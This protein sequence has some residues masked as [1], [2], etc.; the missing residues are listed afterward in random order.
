MEKIGKHLPNL[1]CL[2]TLTNT[3]SQVRKN[4]IEQQLQSILTHIA[5]WNSKQEL[6]T[7]KASPRYTSAV[8]EAIELKQWRFPYDWVEHAT[9]PRLKP[10]KA[11]RWIH[12]IIYLFSADT[13][14]L[15]HWIRHA[16]LTSKQALVRSLEWHSTLRSRRRNPPRTQKTRNT[17]SWLNGIPIS[18][19]APILKLHSQSNC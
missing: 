15:V 9:N 19:H 7:K 1:H 8:M 14:D 10:T 6:K 5:A 17:N 3:G 16:I 4:M 18:F 12:I 13:S 11:S 2:I